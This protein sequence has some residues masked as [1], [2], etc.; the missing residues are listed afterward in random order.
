MTTKAQPTS[1]PVPESSGFT[2]DEMRMLWNPSEPAAVPLRVRNHLVRLG[3]LDQ[4]GK[5]Y[6]LTSKGRVWR[7][8]P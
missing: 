3:L 2:P 8:L 1:N 6:S 7:E 5:T 4:V